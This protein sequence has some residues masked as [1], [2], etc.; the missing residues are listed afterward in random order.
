MRVTPS[1][2]RGAPIVVL[3]VDRAS[4]QPPPPPPRG[5]RRDRVPA[6]A[7]RSRARTGP[8]TAPLNDAVAD[9]LRLHLR[10]EICAERPRRVIEVVRARRAV[11]RRRALAGDEG[12]GEPLVPAA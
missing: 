1:G 7:G 12:L 3:H 6:A 11:A 2:S 4:S 9:R 8:V 5:A 10:V